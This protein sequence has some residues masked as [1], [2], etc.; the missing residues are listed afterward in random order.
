MSG[1]IS[2]FF[3]NPAKVITFTSVNLSQTFKSRKLI[4]FSSD[5]MK[6]YLI[7]IVLYKV[8][9]REQSFVRITAL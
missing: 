3:V 7:Y 8:E 2:D 9:I 5:R 4:T 6:S 1:K